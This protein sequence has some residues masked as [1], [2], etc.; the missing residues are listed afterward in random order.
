LKAL[1]CKKEKN[2]V[3]KSEGVKSGWSNSQWNRQDWQN[4]PKKICFAN[5]DYDDD[6]LF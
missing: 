4:L 2:Y 5:V 3:A 6:G 1:L